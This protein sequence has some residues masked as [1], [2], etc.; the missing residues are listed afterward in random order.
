VYH[1]D[2]CTPDQAETNFREYWGADRMRDIEVRHIPFDSAS[3]RNPWV[4]NVIGIGLSAGF[5]EPLEA[6]GLNWVITSGQIL[7]QS[8]VARYYDPDTS[9]KYNFNMLGYV[10]DVQDFIDAHYKLSARRDT[11]YWKYQAS[12]DFPDRLEQRLALYA[13]EMPTNRNR[14]KA[15]PWAFHEL[16]WIDILNGYNFRYEKLDIDPRLMEAADAAIREISTR[17]GPGAHPLQ[18]RPQPHARG[19]QILVEQ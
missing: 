2:F 18:C 15:T 4:E 5:I 10:Y 6:T 8:L 1:G 14:S 3:L 19:P 12:R 7:C 17:E 13:V 9:A 11:E 16:S